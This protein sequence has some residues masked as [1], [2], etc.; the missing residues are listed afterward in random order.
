[1]KFSLVE[2]LRDKN[3]RME[4]LAVMDTVGWRLGLLVVGDN[5]LDIYSRTTCQSNGVGAQECRH[6]N[7]IPFPE[8]DY[9]Y[10]IIGAA[11]GYKIFFCDV[12]GVDR[13]DHGQNKLCM[14]TALSAPPYHPVFPVSRDVSSSSSSPYS[15]VVNQMAQQLHRMD[16]C[17]MMLQEMIQRDRQGRSFIRGSS[18]DASKVMSFLDKIS[19]WDGFIQDK[20][21]TATPDVKSMAIETSD[22]DQN[23]V[24][25][26]CD[27]PSIQKI[28]L[29]EIM[30]QIYWLAKD[31]YGNYVV[32]E[33]CVAMSQD[34]YSSNVIE[35]CL[36][37]GDYD[38]DLQR[39][40]A[41]ND[42]QTTEDS[43]R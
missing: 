12:T 41:P 3:P 32:Q 8:P 17:S 15:K 36:T 24:L 2:L 43:S 42:S 25:E 20:I 6:D 33:S 13:D 37:Y 30:E 5:M 40:A 19:F 29:S 4:E 31:Q 18:E 16:G 1:M 14:V 23:R 22:P 11:E 34:K 21:A 7:Y 26:Y 27:D 28:I 10:S 38:G 35:K 9:S 39:L